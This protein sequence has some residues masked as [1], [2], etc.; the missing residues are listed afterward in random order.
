MTLGATVRVRTKMLH[1]SVK[2]GAV[3]REEFL[4]IVRKVLEEVWRER[5]WWLLGPR[6][7]PQDLCV[8]FLGPLDN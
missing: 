8:L 3:N 5:E 1:S 6:D 4:W 7:L 2:H